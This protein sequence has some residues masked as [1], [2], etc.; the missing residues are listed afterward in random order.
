M[1]ISV[2]ALAQA[3]FVPN[4]IELGQALGWRV[5]HELSVVSQISCASFEMAYEGQQ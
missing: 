2:M 4:F 1:G 5:L 3:R